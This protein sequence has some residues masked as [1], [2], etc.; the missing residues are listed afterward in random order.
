MYC[1][2]TYLI[3]CNVLCSHKLIFPCTT[4]NISKE[5]CLCQVS[6][7]VNILTDQL[8]IFLCEMPFLRTVT[9]TFF[10]VKLKFTASSLGPS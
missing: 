9:V 8:Q 6:V 10:K 5:K 1:C 4:L 3:T 7:S 2:I